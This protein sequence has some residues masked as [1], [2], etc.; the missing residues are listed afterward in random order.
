M[1]KKRGKKCQKPDLILIDKS[2][3][4]KKGADVIIGGNFTDDSKEEKFKDKKS[5]V[6]GSRKEIVIE[7]IKNLHN[8]CEKL[9]SN[10]Y[11]VEEVYELL[12]DYNCKYHRVLYSA[13][14]DFIFAAMENARSKKGCDEQLL[15]QVN[16]EN[17]IDFAY[18]QN[19]DS[20]IKVTIKLYDH[21]NLATRQYSSLRDSEDEYAKK[22]KMN[23]EPFKNE[24]IKESNSQLLTLV[25]MF[26][27]LAFLIFG[28]ISSLDNLFSEM[29]DLPVLKL[30]A[31]GCIWGICILN[32]VFIF[33]I[34]VSRITRL[35]FKFT[36]NEDAGIREKYSVIWFCNL[37]LIVVLVFSLGSLYINKYNLGEW[38]VNWTKSNP[39][40]FLALFAIILIAILGIGM[41]LIFY[42]KKR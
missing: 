24:L 7:M 12:K 41:F 28:G 3:E 18:S 19:D 10:D 34:C 14:S 6:N 39:I 29:D 26:T 23:I 40:L 35:P 36:D 2:E 21:I 8:I 30:I 16:I 9:N 42:K 22:F 20:M 5:D 33:L 1:S 38:L 17:L 32:L 13:I 25:G 15:L 11:E 31:L 4:D 27:A 37:I